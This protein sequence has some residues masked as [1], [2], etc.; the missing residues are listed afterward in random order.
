MFF[1]AGTGTKILAESSTLFYLLHNPRVLA[2]LAEE[3]RTTFPVLDDR[4]YQSTTTAELA[5]PIEWGNP[6]LKKMSYLNACIHE[7]MRLSP[8]L[9]GISPRVAGPGGV[10]IDG[11][12]FPEGMELGVPS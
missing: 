10:V 4:A 9:L 7:A 3:V 8:G 6:E 1:T 11:T 2:H 5:C 12:W